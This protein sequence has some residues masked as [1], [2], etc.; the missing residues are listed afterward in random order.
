M[1]VPNLSK[2][3]QLIISKVIPIAILMGLACLVLVI[4]WQYS[5]NLRIQDEMVFAPEVID[6][7]VGVRDTYW[8]LYADGRWLSCIPVIRP[9]EP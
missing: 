6:W 7:R 4:H 8:C 1:R 2:R 9:V 3:G 5:E